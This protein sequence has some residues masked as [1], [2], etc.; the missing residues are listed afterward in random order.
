MIAGLL[1]AFLSGAVALSYEILW[2]RAFSFVS[3]SRADTFGLLLGSYLIGLALGALGAHKYCR[4]VDRAGRRG[5]LSSLVLLSLP[6]NI[7]GFFVVPVLGWSVSRGLPWEYSLFVVA[8]AAAGLGSVFP[9]LA[10]VWIEPDENAGKQ[11]SYIYLANILGS[12]SG[13]LVTG[14]ILTDHL[15]MAGMHVLLGFLALAMI[16]VM[17]A[18]G[19]RDRRL[20]TGIA[21]L[22]LAALNATMGVQ[23]FDG[24]YEKLQDKVG[25]SPQRRFTHV[26][27]TKSGILT[28]NQSDQLFGG[29][30]YDG[31]FN[32]SLQQDKNTILRCYALAD[33]HRSP[34]E[35]LMIGL[36]S[37]SWATVVANNP[38]VEH[39]TVVEI[40]AG[41]LQLLPKY[42]SVAGLL[43]NPKVTI[44]IDDGRRWLVRNGGRKFDLIVANATLNWRSNST[45][46]LSK[47][48]LELVRT[49]LNPGGIYYYNTTESER[50]TRTGCQ[51]FPHALKIGSFL[52]VS[53]S[54][55]DLNFDRVRELLFKYPR[56]GGVTLDRSLPGDL[57]LMDRVL[58][59]LRR[60]TR[61]REWILQMMPDSRPVT[62]DNM[63]TEWESI[64]EPIQ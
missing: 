30:A 43:Q 61:S 52:A 28:V 33:L 40:N 32:T 12:T 24:I 21:L 36:G 35:A 46:L 1:L 17:V 31:A 64:S 11:V 26:V 29:G 56:D 34:R 39:L 62:D 25:Y 10:H 47:E 20:A 45:N 57:E 48:F 38:A 58:L 59:S 4:D 51:V 50:V 27:E 53:D 44:E 3:G 42:P 60:I 18:L 23:A 16:G 8:V 37:G 9:L 15:T 13:S 6:A 22:A 41:Y 7:L 63:G 49:R 14:F 5:L 2:Y 55:L 19:P 54:P